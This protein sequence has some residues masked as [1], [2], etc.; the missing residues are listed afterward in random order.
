MVV[1]LPAPLGP[2]SAKNSPGWTEKETPST[3]F[4]SAF[5]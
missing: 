2:S 3:A 4:F 1:V 5:L